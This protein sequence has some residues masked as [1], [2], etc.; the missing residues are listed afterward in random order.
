MRVAVEMKRRLFEQ[1]LERLELRLR[2][3]Q[4][5]VKRA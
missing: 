1:R 4:A 3:L 5:G 2:S